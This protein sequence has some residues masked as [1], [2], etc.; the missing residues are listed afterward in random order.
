MF[1]APGN[2][3]E[4]FGVIEA[5]LF[6]VKTGTI[7]FTSFERFEGKRRANVWHVDLKWDSLKESLVEQSTKALAHKVK[8]NCHILDNA[9]LKHAAMGVIVSPD[10]RSPGRM[11]T[12]PTPLYVPE[13]RVTRGQD[14]PERIP[15]AQPYDTSS[16]H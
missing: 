13:R 15:Y 9:R 10:R 5:T 16:D 2:T 14:T 7:L 1:I 12:P 6:D 4:S 8:E 3:L 11:T